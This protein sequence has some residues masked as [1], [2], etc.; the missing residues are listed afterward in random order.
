MTFLDHSLA[1]LRGE[2]FEMLLVSLVGI[3]ILALAVVLWRI[4][5]SPFAQTLPYMLIIVAAIFIMAGVWS[6]V[7]TPRQTKLYTESFEQDPQAFVVTEQKRVAGFERTYHYTIIGA[8]VAF[9]VAVLLFLLSNNI[10]ARSSA[11]AIVFI[12]FSGLVIDM[13]S[14]HR[15]QSYRQAIEQEIARIEEQSA[16]N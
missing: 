16:K 8:A 3:I 12:G 13:F 5:Q 11:V 10:W 15:A 9:T 14:E 2:A 7:M 4:G 1:W 6:Y